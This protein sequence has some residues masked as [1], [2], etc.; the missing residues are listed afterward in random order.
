MK[1]VIYK[2]DPVIYPFPVLVTKKFDSKELCELFYAVNTDNELQDATDDTFYPNRYTI[3]RTVEVVSKKTHLKYFLILLVRPSV[4]GNGT[5]TH[6]SVH[7][8]NM[9]AE[10]CGFL[11]EKAMQDEPQAYLAQWIANCVGYTKSGKPELM[12]GVLFEE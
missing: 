2:F 8:T 6:E 9:I 3:A 10:I 7:A 4:I 5:I 11:P 12:N 1:S